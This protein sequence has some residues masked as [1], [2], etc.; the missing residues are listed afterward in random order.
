MPLRLILA[1]VLLLCAGGTAR[2]HL[3]SSSYLY[4]AMTQGGARGQW[5]IALRDLDAVVGLDT[6]L[7]GSITW[8][9]LKA[10]QAAVESYALSR[11]GLSAGGRP[12]RLRATGFLVDYHAGYAYAVIRFDA[13][14]PAA[15]APLVLDYRLLFDID[16]TH[17]GLLTVA[18]SG[19]VQ[20][21]VLAPDASRVAIAPAA[22]TKLGEIA[23][24]LLFGFNHILLG[25]DHLLFIA[26]LLITASLRRPSGTRWIPIDSLGRVISETLKTLTAFTLAHGIS[27]T[28]AVL[29]IVDIP[30]RIVD[31]AVAATIMLAAVDNVQPFLMR[32]RW[33]IAFAFGLVH[34]LSFA[35]ALG[36]MRLPAADLAIALGCFNLGV[37]A[38]QAALALLLVPITFTLRVEA[39]YRRLMAP[40]LSAAAFALA[41]L[42]FVDRVFALD[43]LSLHPAAPLLAA[44]APS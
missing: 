2:A 24:F 38:G 25:Y 40:A 23:R 3:V 14:C 11:L 7:D 39:L 27:L 34:G 12:C 43:L 20:T 21:A 37:E 9:E 1:V 29:G 33:G 44:M 42:W 17:R 6:D 22:Q 15:A 4:L 10:K 8:G 35:A 28:L 19:G 41:A 16:P 5:D 18:G 30:G 13:A 31:P 32:T 36:P 26:V